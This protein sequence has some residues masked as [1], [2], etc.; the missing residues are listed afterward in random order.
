MED[1]VQAIR[2]FPLPLTQR[3]VREFLG[4]VNVYHSFVPSCAQTLQPLHNNLLKM[5]PK[6]TSPLTWTEAA[7]VT[8]QSI[9]DALAIATLL[10]HPLNQ[11][12]QPASSLMPPAA[13]RQNVVL[14]CVLF[15]E[16]DSYPAEVCT[17][18]CELLAIYL[19]V[20]HFHY[21]VEG[22]YIVTDYKPLTY[23]LHSR[24]TN[25]SPH[26]LDYISQFTSDIR[27][28]SGCVNAAVDTLSH[29]EV[30]ALAGSP[31]ITPQN[32][33]ITQQ[34]EDVADITGDTSLDLP[35]VSILATEVTLLCDVTTGTLRP[36]MPQKLQRLIFD[37]LHGLFH[38]GIHATQRLIASSTSGPA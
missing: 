15:P 16:V 1:K 13:D 14:P 26:Q 10:V 35:H 33:A 22:C 23:A 38:P 20:K 27:H 2:D 18:D 4:L 28:L 36:Y 25:H 24:S 34:E 21:F 32:L 6:V 8:F 30:S 5:A 37:H 9:K 11:R 7:T 12:P 31:S 3:K 19:A 29:I 17:F